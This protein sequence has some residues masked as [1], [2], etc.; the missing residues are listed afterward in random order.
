MSSVVLPRVNVR[1]LKDGAIAVQGGMGAHVSRAQLSGLVAWYGWVGVVSFVALDRLV[2]RRLGLSRMPSQREAA[3]IEIA[4]A[5][6]LS[7]GRGM[8]GLNVMVALSGYEKSV[9]G[10]WMPGLERSLP[11]RVFRQTYRASPVRA[12]WHSYRSFPPDAL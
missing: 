5:I 6:R 7:G 12:R 11:E 9:Y 3:R 1:G 4:E 10:A 2:K 8:I